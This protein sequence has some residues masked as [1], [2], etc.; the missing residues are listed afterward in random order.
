MAFPESCLFHDLRYYLQV[1]EFVK[2]VIRGL[3][4]RLRMRYRIPP[5]SCFKRIVRPKF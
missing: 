2:S 3:A 1:F 4:T 5:V